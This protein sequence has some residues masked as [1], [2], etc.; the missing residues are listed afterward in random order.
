MKITRKEA[1]IVKP[2]KNTI[3]YS[4]PSNNKN[5]SVA[6]IKVNGRH[7]ENIGE[8][9]IEMKCHVLFYFIKGF[10][11]VVIKDQV[12]KITPHDTVIIKSGDKYYLEGKF[13]YLASTSPAYLPEQNKIVRK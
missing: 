2:N 5:I 13:E 6:L 8:Y 3:V 11:K 7:P 12:Y 4:Y 1:F 10:G 9:F